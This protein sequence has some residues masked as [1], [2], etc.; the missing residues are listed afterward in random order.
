MF[1][2]EKWFWD[3]VR[4][5]TL[6]RAQWLPDVEQV[7]KDMRNY[8]DWARNIY[9]WAE[10]PEERFMVLQIIDFGAPFFNGMAGD[11]DHYAL[12]RWFGTVDVGD[13]RLQAEFLARAFEC[14]NL[15]WSE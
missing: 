8:A 12:H 10:A 14:G 6:E 11:R 13:E 9:A 7:M 2:M 15:M 1:Y 5:M 3:K 4:S